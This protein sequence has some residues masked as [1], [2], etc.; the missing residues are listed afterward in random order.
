[1]DHD[2]FMGQVQA[3]ARLDSRGA[4]EAA[5]RATLETLAE[6]VP[7]PLAAKLAAQLPREIGE[8][9]RRVATAPDQP[10][11]GLRM[12]R[13]DFLD[14]LAQRAGADVAKAAYEA[15]GVVEVV[16]EAT[17]GAVLE[18]IRQAMD[19]DLAELLFAGSTGPA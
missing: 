1:M 8:H 13:R 19:D 16:G 12:S 11:G 18:R 6:R 7:A 10:A 5:T 9:L 3:R 4:A 2:T 14:R 15:R 17:E